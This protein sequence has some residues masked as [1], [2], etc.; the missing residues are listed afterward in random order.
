MAVRRLP[1]PPSVDMTPR[2]A[3]IDS[4]HIVGLI[5]SA[6]ADPSTLTPEFL[7]NL[8]RRLSRNNG[9]VDAALRTGVQQTLPESA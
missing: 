9:V 1:S 7:R 3:L 4:S 2:E 6:A 8:G 5:E